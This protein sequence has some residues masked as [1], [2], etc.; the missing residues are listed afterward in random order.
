[1]DQPPECYVVDAASHDFKVGCASYLEAHM[2][3]ADVYEDADNRGLD[4]PI[5][6]VVPCVSSPG[7]RDLRG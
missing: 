6:R 2:F 4:R 3:I 5:L 7:G 1:V